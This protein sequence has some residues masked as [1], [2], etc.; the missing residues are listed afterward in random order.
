MTGASYRGK[1]GKVWRRGRDKR[2]EE[3]SG[4]PRISE[5]GYHGN[6]KL[7]IISISGVLS[8][9]ANAGEE[10]K[11]TPKR[12]RRVKLNTL[13]PAPEQLIYCCRQLGGRQGKLVLLPSRDMRGK[14]WR[15]LRAMK[16]PPSRKKF[17]A[18]P[19]NMN[20]GRV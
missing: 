18:E 4:S 15:E 14:V 2:S 12:D 3:W 10:E 16:F 9:K 8:E 6:R 7:D 13:S 1:G 5:V 17:K 19:R 11:G 20:C